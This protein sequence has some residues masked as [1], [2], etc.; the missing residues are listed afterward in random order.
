VILS[1]K[2]SVAVRE[3]SEGDTQIEKPQTWYNRRHLLRNYSKTAEHLL[4]LAAPLV[5]NQ[6]KMRYK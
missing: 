4:W 6:L 3:M 5:Q 2:I 1:L